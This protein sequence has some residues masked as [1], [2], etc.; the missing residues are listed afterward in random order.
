[1]ESILFFIAKQSFFYLYLLLFIFIF[2]ENT[3]PFLPGDAFLVFSAYLVGKSALNPYTAYLITVISGLLGFCGIY[4]IGH[5]WGREYF[6]R[7][8][9][10]FFPSHWMK[11]ADHYFQRFGN[12]V[13][14]ISRLIPGI[15][16]MTA[17][18][19]GF[20]RIPFIKALLYTFCGIAIWNGLVYIS[21]KIV[22]D[23]WKEIKVLL[24]EYNTFIYI[25][26]IILLAGL[27]A[28]WMWRKAGKEES[29]TSD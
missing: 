20:T 19:A 13:L 24:S 16:F 6:E 8:Q 2:I 1:M 26:L 17:M 22:G 4:W 18:I 29:S 7:K 9:F 23:N 10:K 27:I 5:H 28:Y 14:A 21:V 3:L 15:R 25:A 11:K 12:W